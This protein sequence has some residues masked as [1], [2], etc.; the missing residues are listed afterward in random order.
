MNHF[1]QVLA[2]IVLILSGATIGIIQSNEYLR[3]V[4]LH[5]ATSSGPGP[6]QE[7]FALIANTHGT[8]VWL[9]ILAIAV[10]IAEAV[11]L[12]LIAMKVQTGRLVLDILV[13]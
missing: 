1:L 12:I 11:A 4:L 7:L 3:N 5:G 9:L 2:T 6:F 13:S 10:I 8:A